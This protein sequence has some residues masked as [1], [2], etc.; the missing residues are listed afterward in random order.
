MS[1][2]L[3]QIHIP[4]STDSI[5]VHRAATRTPFRDEP[6]ADGI[7]GRLPAAMGRRVSDS[8]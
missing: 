8:S 7:Y 3:S 6:P 1:P 5:F 2:D 4:M